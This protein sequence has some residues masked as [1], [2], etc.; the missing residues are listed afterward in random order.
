MMVTIIGPASY[1]RGRCT[2]SKVGSIVQNL[3]NAT[4]VAL[5]APYKHDRERG[6]LVGNGPYSAEFTEHCHCCS[7]GAMHA[8]KA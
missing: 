3:L 5:L 2:W 8:Y 4:T 1:H 7:G 6:T